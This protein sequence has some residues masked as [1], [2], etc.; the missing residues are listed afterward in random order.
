MELGPPIGLEYGTGAG[1]LNFT[2]SWVSKSVEYLSRTLWYTLGTAQ[3]RTHF[4][5][6]F[7]TDRALE[8]KAGIQSDAVWTPVRARRTID[9]AS[10]DMLYEP[11][12]SPQSRTRRSSP[13]EPTTEVR[14]RSPTLCESMSSSHAGVL[15]EPFR[16]AILVNDSLPGGV[17]EPLPSRRYWTLGIPEGEARSDTLIPL[18]EG[19]ATI[20]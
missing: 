4:G 13:S 19:T 8:M 14:M 1:A 7:A 6:K 9:K 10:E 16:R 15:T 5:R 3:P 20:R 17:L 2:C 11:P 12:G 18:V